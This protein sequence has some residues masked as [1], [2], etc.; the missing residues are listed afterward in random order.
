MSLFLTLK[1]E[2]MWLKQMKKI[3]LVVYIL[4]LAAMFAGCSSKPIKSEGDVVVKDPKLKGFDK[5]ILSTLTNDSFVFDIE[6]HS[7]KITELP[8]S[9]E[10]YKEGKL[11]GPILKSSAITPE[12][13]KKVR[14]MIAKQIIDDDK[15]AKQ[16]WT[17]ASFSGGVN[18]FF[19]G[20]EDK[21]TTPSAL[22]M[23]STYADLPLE[24]NKGE[25]KTIAAMVS[26]SLNGIVTSDL[27]AVLENP[28]ATSTFDLVYLV[29]IEA[30]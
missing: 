19:S 4:L 11:V 12:G 1:Y 14:L 21:I 28:K 6:T 24:L 25:K 22:S 2:E 20:L 23:A 8:V 26:T 7:E 9:I 5:Q 13:E 15:A 16:N 27:Q 10:L 17:I 30:K 3:F 29:R 18:S